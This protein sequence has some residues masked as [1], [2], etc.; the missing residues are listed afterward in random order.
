VVRLQTR[1]NCHLCPSHTKDLYQRLNDLKQLGPL[2]PFTRLFT[3]DDVSMYTNIDTKHGIQT[4]QKWSDLHRTEILGKYPSFPFDLIMELL[5][6]VMTK[7][8]FQFD[9]CWLQQQNG[10]AMGMS[11]ACIYATIYYSYM[12]S[13]IYL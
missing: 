3:A 13:R 1:K 12:K 8:V 4:I 6:L 7:I 10:T 2:P 11:V 5:Q 9:Y